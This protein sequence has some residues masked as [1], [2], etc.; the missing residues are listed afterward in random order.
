MDFGRGKCE[1]AAGSTVAGGRWSCWAAWP[2]RG[3]ELERDRPPGGV[4]RELHETL[5]CG[6]WESVLK[7]FLA[8][9]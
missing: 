6:G 7:L 8:P 1:L 3:S 5:P 2:P 4:V 9:W